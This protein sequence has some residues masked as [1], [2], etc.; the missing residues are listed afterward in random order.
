M[1]IRINPYN[2]FK[3][4]SVPIFEIEPDSGQGLQEGESVTITVNVTAPTNESKEFTGT[5][6]MIN[7]DDPTDFC[8]IDMYLKTPRS[9]TIY[10]TLFLKL[11]E[12][13]PNAFP[14]LRQLLGL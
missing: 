13:F 1:I 4:P 2:C 10:N 7:S 8:E 11:F 5:I 6:K 9:R 14:I 12:R 3:N